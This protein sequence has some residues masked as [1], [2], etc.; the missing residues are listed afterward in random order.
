VTSET[1]NLGIWGCG[2]HIIKTQGLLGLYKGW[3]AT[4][5]VITYL[6]ILF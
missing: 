5:I 3:F 4:M 6:L 1:A 2:K